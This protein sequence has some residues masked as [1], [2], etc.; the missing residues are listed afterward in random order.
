MVDALSSRVLRAPSAKVDF[1]D[2]Q[3]IRLNEPGE[4]PATV[5]IDLRS[6]ALII[7]TVAGNVYASDLYT[8]NVKNIRRQVR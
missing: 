5:T 8:G 3:E 7:T 2:L 4:R 6:A 1:N